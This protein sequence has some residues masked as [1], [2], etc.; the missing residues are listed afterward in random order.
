MTHS[1]RMTTRNQRDSAARLSVETLEDRTLLA[2]SLFADLNPATQG[3]G[4][5][6]LT[7]VDGEV[8]I[9]QNV[10]VAEMLVDAREGDE[11][12]SHDGQPSR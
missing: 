6:D 7:V 5:S 10:Q 3:A 12:F 4:P 9:L 2:A 8:D 1:S 11:R